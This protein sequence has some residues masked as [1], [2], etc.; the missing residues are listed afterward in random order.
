MLERFGQR[1]PKALA[2]LRRWYG[3]V[4]QAEWSDFIQTRAVFPQADQV[5]TASGRTATVF[6]VGGNKFRVITAIHYNRQ[7]VY[8]MRV[9]THEEY[10]VIDWKEQL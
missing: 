6:N 3:A 8:V 4:A 2:P 9:Y 10:D 5:R 7:I 1:H